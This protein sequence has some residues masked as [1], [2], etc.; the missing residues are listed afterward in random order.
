MSETV[1][2]I[3]LPPGRL[4]QSIQIMQLR[5]TYIVSALDGLDDGVGVDGSSEV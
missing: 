2:G 1:Q 4:R 3:Q 5:N